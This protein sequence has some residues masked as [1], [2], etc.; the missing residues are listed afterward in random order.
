MTKNTAARALW[1]RALV[2]LLK[3]IQ[4]PIIRGNAKHIDD[5]TPANAAFLSGI[6]K[7]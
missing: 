6:D 1:L 4:K 3:L 7:E 5:S 2:D